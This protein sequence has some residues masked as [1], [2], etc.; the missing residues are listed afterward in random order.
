VLLADHLQLDE[1]LLVVLLAH[2]HRVLLHEELVLLLHQPGGALHGLRELLPDSVELVVLGQALL[3]H[4]AV[5]VD[6]GLQAD[7]D[8][9]RGDAVRPAAGP[10][11]LLR[12]AE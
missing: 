12:A 7:Q 10:A 8:L 11:L 2:Q 6:H 5:L 4:R 3:L 1:C 9:Q